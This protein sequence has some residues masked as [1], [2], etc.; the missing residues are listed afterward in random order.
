MGSTVEGTQ[1][2]EG[3]LL[4]FIILKRKTAPEGCFAVVGSSGLP[5]N[6]RTAGDSPPRGLAFHSRLAAP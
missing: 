1:R 4:P 2:K 3:F 5:W 6:L